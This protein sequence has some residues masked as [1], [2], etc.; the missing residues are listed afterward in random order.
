MLADSKSWVS[1]SDAVLD[2]NKRLRNARGLVRAGLNGDEILWEYRDGRYKAA[3]LD[4][5]Y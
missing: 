1:A 2:D 3:F 5:P 4:R